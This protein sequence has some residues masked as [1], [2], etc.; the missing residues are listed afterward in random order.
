MYGNQQMTR[1]T[2]SA[3]Q[4]SPIP[5]LGSILRA[6]PVAPLKKI[7]HAAAL[8]AVDMEGLAE[9]LEVNRQHMYRVIKGERPSARL[10][11]RIA[12]FLNADVS[13]IWPP[14]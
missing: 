2:Y 8:W 10:R 1:R 13:D 4:C 7:R 12:G 14:H 9:L 3:T 6:S 5:P 11:E